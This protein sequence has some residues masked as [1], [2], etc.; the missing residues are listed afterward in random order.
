MTVPVA[1]LRLI[2]LDADDVTVVAS[3][4]QDAVGVVGDMAYQPRERRFVM[5]L[6]RY[7]WAEAAADP[8]SLG[9]GGGR[10]GGLLLA[11]LLGLLVLGG[12]GAGEEHRQ[13]QPGEEGGAGAQRR[14]NHG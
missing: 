6:N 2:A 10:R 14:I 1:P 12:A 8:G 3:H 9:F 5:L 4:L 7:D 13:Q 11:R